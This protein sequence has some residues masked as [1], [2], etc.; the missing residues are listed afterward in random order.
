VAYCLLVQGTATDAERASIDNALGVSSWP[1]PVRQ[2]RP[3]A[4]SGAPAWWAGDED[5]S[6]SFLAEMGVTLADGSQG[7]TSG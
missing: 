1:G 5:A 6:Q 7:V 4:E 3:P 2:P